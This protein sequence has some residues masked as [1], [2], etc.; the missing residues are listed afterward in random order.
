MKKEYLSFSGIQDFPHHQHR[1]K[2]NHDYRSP[3]KYHITLTKTENAPVFGYLPKHFDFANPENIKIERNAL[4]NV[5]ARI[6]REIPSI[7]PR[8]AI[9]QYIVMP[10]H[11]HFL[12]H[13]KE[14][15]DQ[16]LGQLIGRIKAYISYEWHRLAPSSVNYD[17]F[18]QG[19][20]DKIIFQ[21][22]S[23]DDVFKYIRLNPY[24]LAIRKARPIFFQ[25][26][27]NIYIDDREIQAYGNLFHLRN[28]FIYNLI[29]HRSDD[30]IIYNSKREYSLHHAA[31]GGV[32]ISAF[33]SKREKEIRKD[34]EAAGGKIILIK[35]RPFEDREK[36][37]RHDFQLCCEGRILI[38]SPLD[39]LNI[40]PTEH[41]TRA[42]C[43]DMNALSEKI[44]RGNS[45]IR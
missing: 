21:H 13:V 41:P 12:I 11:V 8:T 27:R 44:A 9:Y 16:P 37:A 20:N 31:N 19:F 39:Y 14:A 3:C 36:P 40:P 25:K 43:L 23:L 17:I 33:I 22:R 32:V 24:R 34:I 28:P 1:R 18:T 30:D 35:N 45:I 2:K 7:E 38:I 26:V 4:G 6:I 42:Q 10:D 29:I 15:L 5:I